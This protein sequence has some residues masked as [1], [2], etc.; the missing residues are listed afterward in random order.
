RGSNCYLVAAL[1]KENAHHLTSIFII[2]D[3]E[4]SFPA[5]LRAR[6]LAGNSSGIGSDTHFISQSI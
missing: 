5:C 3:T 2:I 1:R 6:P 4:Q